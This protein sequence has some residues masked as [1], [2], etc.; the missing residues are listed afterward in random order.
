MNWPTR[1]LS[2]GLILV[3]LL[4]LLTAAAPPSLVAFE[5]GP[6]PAFDVAPF[7]LPNCPPG[8]IRFEETR[9]LVAVELTLDAPPG[10]LGLSYLQDNWPR[11]DLEQAKDLTQPCQFG[12]TRVDDWF[13]GH[14]RSAKT[15]RDPRRGR[16]RPHRIR[17]ADE[18]VPRGARVRCPLPQ[19]PGPADR[20]SEAQRRSSR[21]GSSPDRTRYGRCSGS[22]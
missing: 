14:W 16:S 18:G 13:N 20:G 9:D 8:E 10:S 2:L 17:A 15:H 22:S 4:L 11:T 19:D 6:I 5:T 1:S 21:F 7:A 3:D 12:W